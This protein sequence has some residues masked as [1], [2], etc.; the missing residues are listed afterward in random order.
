MMFRSAVPFRFRLSQLPE[1]LRAGCRCPASGCRAT[2]NFRLRWMLAFSCAALCHLPAL[3]ASEQEKNA[4]NNFPAGEKVQQEL[5]VV[6]GGPRPRI[7]QGSISI[8]EGQLRVIRNLSVQPSAVG[9]MVQKDDKTI[10]VV[11]SVETTFGGVDISVDGRLSSKLQFQ[12]RNG[13][14]DTATQREVSVRDLKD[15]VWIQPIGDSGER[16]AVERQ[17]ADKLR[18][19]DDR[20]S[21]VFECG[22]TWALKVSGDRTGLAG[23]EY[24]LTASWAGRRSADPVISLPVSL[25]ADG[26]FAP[27]ELNV[28]IPGSEGSYRLELSLL[29]PSL[30]RPWS[31]QQKPLL[32]R[33]VELVAFASDSNPQ[34]VTGWRPLLAIDTV[35]ATNTGNL[36]WLVS[37]ANAPLSARGLE[38]SEFP[39]LSDLS[40][41]EQWQRLLSLSKTLT[42]NAPVQRSGGVSTRDFPQRSSSERQDKVQTCV[43]IEPGAWLALP[44]TELQPGYPHKLRIQ[45]PS[46][47]SGMLNVVIKDTANRDQVAISPQQTFYLPQAT[48]ND[49]EASVQV[50]FLFWPRTDSIQIVLSSGHRYQSASVGKIL[51]EAARLGSLPNTSAGSIDQQAT[52]SSGRK[53]GLY[54]DQPF[55]AESL[56]APREKDP[57]TGRPL[58]TWA[59]FQAIAERLVLHLQLSG[60]NTLVLLAAGDGGCLFPVRSMPTVPWIDKSTFFTDGRSPDPHDF[61]EL[62]LKHL[63][64]SGMR[65]VIELDLNSSPPLL[66]EHPSEQ[67]DL[68]QDNLLNTFTAGAQPIGADDQL[69][70]SPFKNQLFNPLNPRVQASVGDVIQEVVQRY[71]H[72]PALEGISLRLRPNSRAIFGG[73]NTGY[74]MQLLLQYAKDSGFQL[75][76]DRQRLTELLSGSGR[77][78][79]L[80]WRASQLTKFYEQQV[81]LVRKQAPEINL[82]LNTIRLWDADNLQAKSN[83]VEEVL[84]NPEHYLLGFGLDM[85]GLAAIEGLLVTQGSARSGWTSLAS[86]R[87]IRESIAENGA[88]LPPHSRQAA[89]ISHQP[90]ALNLE[91]DQQIASETGIGDTQT[92]STQ[93]DS[94]T[95]S[96]AESIPVSKLY[97]DSACI[98]DS[99]RQVLMDQLLRADMQLIGFGGW[100]PV[101]SLD[102]KVVEWIAA[103]KGLPPAVLQDL[104]LISSDIPIRVR[105][106]THQGKDYLVLLN[107]SGL[108]CEMKLYCGGGK[109]PTFHHLNSDDSALVAVSGQQITIRLAP[110]KLVAWRWEG[111]Q[112]VMA[113]I[114]ITPDQNAVAE[115]TS[116]LSQLEANLA[117]ASDTASQRILFHGSGT[118]EQWPDVTKPIGWN[119]SS[120]PKTVIQQAT[121]LPHS[122]KSCIQMENSNAQPASAWI[123]STAIGLPKT[124]RLALRAWLRSSAADHRSPLVKLGVIGRLKNGRRYE[125]SIYYGGL[126][127]AARPIAN[128]WGRRPAELHLSDVPVDE[129]VDMKVAIDLVG[130]GRVWVDDV[131]VVET[132]LHPDERNYLR[133][134]LLIAKQKLAE[135]NPFPAEKLLQSQWNLFLLELESGQA[136]FQTGRVPSTGDSQELPAGWN[137][138]KS[139]FQNWR[140]AWLDRWRR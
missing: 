57:K 45:V 104:P 47:R 52:E 9:N 74:N 116:S 103:Y 69:T 53:V 114:D 21:K 44:L 93:V 99:A 134:Q 54:L 58:E 64:R 84:R 24:Q 60:A 11:A 14:D 34:T 55:L 78:G 132:W 80:V 128:D 108:E 96:S 8:D 23:G 20:T 61:V 115:L 125:H 102:P 101:W 113:S 133:G 109:P 112:P 1:S 10:E 94:S 31:S 139:S 4:A 106:G 79:Y 36:S 66:A 32:S 48:S 124:G 140:E 22:D 75:P 71:K 28:R 26:S 119:V 86:N 81:R 67:I 72:S 35:A 88:T 37:L 82:Y 29:K 51:V 85:E 90:R 38:I 41:P 27:I 89:L 87:W 91:V 5:R 3:T 130:E 105:T 131:E 13:S 121:E 30:V 117:R 111:T 16:L 33:S 129:L 70:L 126:D 77:Y 107:A 127:N 59:T 7:Y 49:A 50:E 2:T 15:G 123:Q 18:I 118:F 12:I 43:T 56:S 122:G 95:D 136:Q 62:L 42:N 92:E 25:D 6:W 17:I 40:S 100:Y 63:E 19:A 83:E 65:L 120:L 39:S 98:G 110:G 138:P 73:L 76:T 46:D 97:V 135:S 137:Q 68:Y